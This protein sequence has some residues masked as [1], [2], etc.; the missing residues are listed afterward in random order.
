MLRKYLVLLSISCATALAA[1]APAS[2]ESIREVLQITQARSLLDKMWPQIDAMMTS[3]MQQGL[4]GKDFSL[5]QR[6]ALGQMQTKMVNAM[7][8]ELSWEK[9][10]PMYIEIYQ[11]SF[12]Q[13]ELDGVLAFYKSPAGA[14]L[15][16]KM[17]IVV[18]ETM[19]AMQRR[20]GPMMERM[21]KSVQESV[22][23]L[24]ER[25]AKKG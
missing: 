14:A 5:E 16:K 3:A 4:K 12:T 2:A 24:K 21:Q 9:L 19:L 17:P 23:Q 22:E 7:R 10:E 13:E 25:S 8:E 15:I 20:V 6:Q 18:Q 11:K 1:E